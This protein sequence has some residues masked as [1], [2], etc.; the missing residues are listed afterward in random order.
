MQVRYAASSRQDIADGLDAWVTRRSRYE[1]DA[2]RQTL[3]A[4]ELVS[5][6]GMLLQAAV[7]SSSRRFLHSLVA[8]TAKHMR[9]YQSSL[10]LLH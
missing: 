4:K 8:R 3:L 6:K 10:I 5:N 9:T 1:S 7:R 2:R